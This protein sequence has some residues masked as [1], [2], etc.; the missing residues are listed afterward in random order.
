MSLIADLAVQLTPKETLSAIIADFPGFYM[1]CLVGLLARFRLVT[2]VR[3][4]S[5][6]STYY[7]C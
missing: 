6:V 7:A 1:L 3:L 5:Q 2:L 4:V